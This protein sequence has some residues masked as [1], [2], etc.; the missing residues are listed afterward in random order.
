MAQVVYVY[1][2]S[3]MNKKTIMK[4]LTAAVF[5]ITDCHSLLADY[6]N[7]DSQI[8]FSKSCS[9]FCDNRIKQWNFNKND[10]LGNKDH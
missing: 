5:K 4:V 8:I 9:M 10:F 7:K 1:K 6:F 3:S 2:H